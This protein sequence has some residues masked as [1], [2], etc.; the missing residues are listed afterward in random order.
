[1]SRLRR[2]P[3]LSAI[4]ALL[5]LAGLT[6]QT[7]AGWIVFK[8]HQ[9]THGEPGNV[10]GPSGYLW[11]WAAGLAQLIAYAALAALLAQQAGQAA[12]RARGDGEGELRRVLDRHEAILADLSRRLDAAPRGAAERRPPTV[13]DERLPADPVR[14]SG[15]AGGRAP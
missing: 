7:Y 4:L 5:F 15:Q 10:L 14:Q 8:A 3:A 1:M 9:Q 2:I 12:A 11:P 6:V 13:T